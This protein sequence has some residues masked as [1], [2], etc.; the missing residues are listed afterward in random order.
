MTKADLL[1]MWHG[2]LTDSRRRSP[3]TVRAYVATAARLLDATGLE[4]WGALARIDA[5]ALRNQLA[6]RRTEGLTNASAA[7]EGS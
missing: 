2:H 6:S 4:T 7:R 1:E 5:A 3:H